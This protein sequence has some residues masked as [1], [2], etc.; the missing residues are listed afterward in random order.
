M[1]DLEVLRGVL[2]AGYA[3]SGG[4][5]LGPEAPHPVSTSSLGVTTGRTWPDVLWMVIKNPRLLSVILVLA[6]LLA[7]VAYDQTEPGS[8]VKV[9]GYEIFRKHI[10]AKPIEHPPPAAAAPA[11]PATIEK[12]RPVPSTYTPAKPPPTMVALASGVVIYAPSSTQIDVTDGRAGWPFYSEAATI[13]HPIRY[14]YE[15][16]DG[17]TREEQKDVTAEVVERCRPDTITD[18]TGQLSKD[19]Q[20]VVL[21]CIP[22][23]GALGSSIAIYWDDSPG[24]CHYPLNHNYEKLIYTRNDVVCRQDGGVRY[25]L[26]FEDQTF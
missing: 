12:P 19:S 20:K 11:L 23:K 3:G 21:W 6:A 22:G 1:R 18:L 17:L 14:R 16:S 2:R 5:K 8:M 13:S 9:F 4:R 15:F 25:L 7:Y 24:Q 26:A 10:V